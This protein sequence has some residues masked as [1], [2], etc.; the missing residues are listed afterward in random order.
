ML[1]SSHLI[2][3]STL[4]S[5]LVRRGFFF[6]LFVTT[7]DCLYHLC[8]TRP[9][10]SSLV[11]LISG[12]F[13]EVLPSSILKMVPSILQGVEPN[14]KSLWW[15]FCYI[16]C[17]RW[18]FSFSCG[19]MFYLYSSSSIVW[20]CLLLTIPSICNFPFLQAF[21]FLLILGALFLPLFVICPFSSLKGHIFLGHTLS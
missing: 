19:N 1:S 2:D 18:V 21:R 14:S 16:D 8:D 13:T 15:Y 11:F 9:H 7:I 17:F 5:M 12:P 4:S 20:W 6:F 3:I 10:A